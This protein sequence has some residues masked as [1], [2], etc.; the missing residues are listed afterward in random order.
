MRG[1]SR[2]GG[3]SLPARG[4]LESL[5][6]FGRCYGAAFSLSNEDKRSFGGLIAVDHLH[7]AG[8]NPRVA[9][10]WQD[11]AI[12]CCTEIGADLDRDRRGRYAEY[13]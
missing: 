6:Q 1:G 8:D 12:E 7:S 3:I 9:Q 13:A 10:A 11:I 5:C 4:G 2:A